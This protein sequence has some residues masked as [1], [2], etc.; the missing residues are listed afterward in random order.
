MYEPGAGQC[1]GARPKQIGLD[2]HVSPEKLAKNGGM[3]KAIG[4]PLFP[5]WIW[6]H[7]SFLAFLAA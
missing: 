1:P 5:S 2:A 3:W 7:K 6:K 4:F